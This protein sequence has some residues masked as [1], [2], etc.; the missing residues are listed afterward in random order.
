MSHA[1]T[2]KKTAVKKE[3]KW[4]YAYIF[5]TTNVVKKDI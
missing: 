1:H 3:R 4:Q 2:G 5:C